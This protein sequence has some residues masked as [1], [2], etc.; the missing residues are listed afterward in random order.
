M[1]ARTKGI[2]ILTLSLATLASACND[3]AGSPFATGR[4]LSS[5][6]GAA[7]CLSPASEVDERTVGESRSSGC[8]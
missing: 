4:T 6:G 8:R 2:A 5:E 3:G 7:S 1:N